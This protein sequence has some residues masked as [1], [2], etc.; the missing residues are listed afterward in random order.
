MKNTPH[1]RRKYYTSYRVHCPLHNYLVVFH[2]VLHDETTR[3]RINNII[4]EVTTIQL[5]LDH[6]VQSIQ[7]RFMF[8]RTPTYVPL[9]NTIRSRHIVVDK[10]INLLGQGRGSEWRP[11]LRKSKV[12]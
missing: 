4:T 12:V 5:N 7:L 2:S 3:F 6:S 9:V 10:T 11:R 8:Y 1:S